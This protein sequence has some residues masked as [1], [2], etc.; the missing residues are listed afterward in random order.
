[1]FDKRSYEHLLKCHEYNQKNAVQIVEVYL[2]KRKD[3]L[4]QRGQQ[5]EVKQKL[6]HKDFTVKIA[7]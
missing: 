4:T 5:L 6:K 7:V 2:P 1:M 3:L